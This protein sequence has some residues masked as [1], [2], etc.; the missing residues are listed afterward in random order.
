MRIS[1][2]S[3]DVCS[4]DLACPRL[5]RQ[6]ARGRLSASRADRLADRAAQREPRSRRRSTVSDAARPASDP[7][8]GH[9]LG[10]VER[11][12]QLARPG[13]F[14]RLEDRSE[15]HTPELPSLLRTVYDGFCSQNNRTQR[16]SKK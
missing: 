9:S 10:T 15:E 7:S 3:S 13:R 5:W 14:T 4:S 1:D 11:A 6:A 2:W 8:P 16:Y 12:Y